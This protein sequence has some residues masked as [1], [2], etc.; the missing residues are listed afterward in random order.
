ML[1]PQTPGGR[2]SQLPHCTQCS[3]M[4][5]A[6]PWTRTH[7][8]PSCLSSCRA[9]WRGL[10]VVFWAISCDSCS[11]APHVQA[12]CPHGHQICL[13]GR[14]QVALK[15]HSKHIWSRSVL[16]NY[17]HPGPPT[18]GTPSGKLVKLDQVW[19]GS[20]ALLTAAGHCST[21][22]ARVMFATV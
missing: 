9:G 2:R 5:L 20:K 7:Q 10:L 4:A 11:D 12:R 3:Q 21:Q 19:L 6:S 18:V 17:K 8:P 15:M 1:V 14:L 13:R 22:H 16:G